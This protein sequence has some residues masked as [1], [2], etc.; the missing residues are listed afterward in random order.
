MLRTEH[1]EIV[2]QHP[3]SITTDFGVWQVLDLW[4]CWASSSL[5]HLCRT[6]HLHIA[7]KH[8][9]IRHN[10]WQVLEV[11]DMQGL[12][13]ALVGVQGLT[14]LSVGQ[15]KRL[16]IAVELVANPSIVFMDE[17]TSGQQVLGPPKLLFH[18]QVLHVSV[19]QCKHT[20]AAGCCPQTP[21]GPL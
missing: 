8:H 12:R 17:P 15:R 21:Q 20:L 1:S 16:T 5:R 3:A 11:V 4:T 7:M 6:R 10:V 13:N 18:L 2:V 14:G 9:A 19:H